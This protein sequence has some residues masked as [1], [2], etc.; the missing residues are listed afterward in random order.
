MPLGSLPMSHWGCFT[1]GTRQLAHGHTQ[2]P[3]C[4][5]PST[6]TPHGWLL[7]PALEGNECE[8]LQTASEHAQRAGST[9]W[10]WE[11]AYK[12][13]HSAP[14][15]GKQKGLCQHSPWLCRVKRRHTILRISTPQ[16]TGNKKCGA[17]VSKKDLRQPQNFQ[18]A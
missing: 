4:L 18:Q 9:L 5:T 7:M 14:P 1:C 6:H 16:P 10:D 8:P 3:A 17:G 15:N 12:L 2:Y 11:K 13:E